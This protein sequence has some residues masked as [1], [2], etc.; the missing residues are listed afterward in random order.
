MVPLINKDCIDN[1]LL[2]DE[3]FHRSHHAESGF[4]A[5]GLLHYLFPYMFK[6]RCCVCLGSGSGFVPRLMR[7]AQYD[8]GIFEDSETILVDANLP[9]AGWGVPDYHDK[10]NFFT[11]NFDV[12]II[13]KTTKEALSDLKNKQIGY[14]HIDADHSYK[15]TKHDFLTY[16][17]MVPV[18]GIITLHDSMVS[19]GVPQLVEEIKKNNKFEICNIR[20]GTGVAIVRKLA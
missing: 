3:K 6:S 2:K 13:K 1:W 19:T 18:H 17:S 9:E 8:T 14:L 10:E 4:L 15:W 20:I 11:Q 12:K 5:G 7:Q 16:S